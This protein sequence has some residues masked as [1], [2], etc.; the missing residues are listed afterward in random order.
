MN[1]RRRVS[2]LRV[3]LLFATL[4]ALALALGLAGFLLDGLFRQHVT[5]QFE[6]TL[7]TH[8]DQLTARLEFDADGSPRIDPAS[9]SDPRWQRPYSGLYWQ[10]DAQAHDG[11]RAGVL[12]SRSLRDTALKFD[13]DAM[14]D[15]D[16]HLHRVS[17]PGG[18]ALLALERSVRSPGDSRG[19]W[20]LAVAADAG[21]ATEAIDRF[22][23]V[24]AASLAVLFLLLGLAAIAQVAI[25]LSP[26]RAMQASLAAVRAGRDDRLRGRFPGEV[27]PLIDEFNQVLAHNDDLVARARTHAGNLAHAIRTP[28]TVIDQAAAGAEHG[29]PGDTASLASLVREQVGTA[30]RHVDRHLARAR[31]AASTLR[32]GV[33]APVA[34]ALAGVAR[35]LARAHAT[36]ELTVEVE[37]EVDTAVVAVDEQDLQEMLGNV[38][39]NAYKWA[40]SRVRVGV[41][42]VDADDGH[43]PDATRSARVVIVVDDD[44]PGIDAGRR[45]A[46]LVRGVREDESTP[47]A[48]L[49][50]SIVQ[51]LALLY[52][53]GL[54]L[55][56]SPMGGLRVRI[57]LPA[58]VAASGAPPATVPTHA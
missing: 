17:G 51:D 58:A 3:R 43:A 54:A 44:G 31:A 49:G 8:L 13:A 28:L 7:A 23:G 20:R 52:G 6:A 55:V 36:R 2:S 29:P 30:R 35:V 45:D 24:I 40:R 39:D 47:G 38:L 33:H 21:A 9:L 53:G 5:R 18:A 34:P 10:L 56:P 4:V 16:A 48:G 1:L 15:G 42:R 11:A 26:L 14:A 19:R 32:S 12:R 46:V 37:P 50:L 27:Q 22:A 41:E 25:G 57:T